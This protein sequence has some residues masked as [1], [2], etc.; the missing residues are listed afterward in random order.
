MLVLH[1]FTTFD[2]NEVWL[3]PSEIT[4]VTRGASVTYVGLSNRESFGVKE[5]VETIVALVNQEI[6]CS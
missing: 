5:S 1:R 6:K 4:S 3:E 2:D